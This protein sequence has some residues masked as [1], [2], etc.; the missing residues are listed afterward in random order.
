MDDF[1]NTAQYYSD[2]YGEYCLKPNNASGHD[3]YCTPQ[4]P[5]GEYEGD[6]DSNDD[7]QTGLSCGTNNCPS[8]LE[9]D[10]W[11]DCCFSPSPGHHDF[12]TPQN[13]CGEHE[14]DCD[15]NDD[16]HTGFVCGS[17]CP[18]YLGYH[19]NTDCCY[20]GTIIHM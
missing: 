20:K 7:C 19:Y 6:C 17:D 1:K 11:V 5:C 18:S 8:S 3:D 16:C 10:L 2:Y 14:G 15:S 12:C 9:F 4:S 13:P